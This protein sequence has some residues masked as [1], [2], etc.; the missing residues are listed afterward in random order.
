[1]SVK[2]ISTGSAA[3]ERILD[4]FQLKQMVDTSDEWIVSRTGIR[5]RRIADLITTEE[6]ASRSLENAIEKCSVKREEIEL[7]IVATI[8]SD[9]KVPSSSYTI[10]GKTGLEKAVCFDINAACSGFI[11]ALSIAK[12]MMEDMGYRYAA[13]I[14][15]E[16][17]SKYVNWEDRTTCVL[18]GDGAGCAILENSEG[19]KKSTK[20]GYSIEI[21]DKK[22][23]GYYDSKKYLTLDSKENID[24]V[25]SKF[26]EM[27]G[28]Q[29]YKFAT[30]EGEKVIRHLCERNKIL[31]ED[32]SMVVAH[33]ANKRIIETLSLKTDIEMEKW[34]INLEKYGNTSSAS[35]P[36]AMDEAL[37]SL[38][39]NKN[40]GK[41]IISAAFGGGLSFGGI[42]LKIL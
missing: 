8:S 26:I 32:I 28:R 14:G 22:I 41:Y 24:D 16:K 6:L 20:S 2:L 31:P 10:A 25:S 13:V 39:F 9:T 42:L 23:G 21:V 12:S 30:N 7:L 18:F 15:A 36:I 33:Q 4:N 3:G 38:D 11:Y 27:N 34:F 35:V 5:E 37:A 40:K 17:L 19:G 29:V 1:M